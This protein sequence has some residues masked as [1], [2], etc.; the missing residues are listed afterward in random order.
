[1]NATEVIRN[2]E[3]PGRLWRVRASVALSSQPGAIDLASDWMPLTKARDNMWD[4]HGA[5]RGKGWDIWLEP[6]DMTA[7]EIGVY[8]PIDWRDAAVH[9][10]AM[11][12]LR[13]VGG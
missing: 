7:E 11:Q 4:C 3:R 6:Q 9:A 2:A 1:M 5:I 10:R 8:V 13:G 12:T